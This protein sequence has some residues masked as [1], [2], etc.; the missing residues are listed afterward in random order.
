MSVVFRDCEYRYEDKNRLYCK[1]KSDKGEC[2]NCK[3]N[4]HLNCQNYV[5]KNDMCLLYFELTG[6]NTTL[7]ISS[8][9]F[10]ICSAIEK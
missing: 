4:V 1:N 8:N 7:S 3:E 6:T 5:P 9:S 10:N 2:D